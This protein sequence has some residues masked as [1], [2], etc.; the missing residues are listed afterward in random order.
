M[1]V[2]LWLVVSVRS[3]CYLAAIILGIISTTLPGISL[4]ETW[5]HFLCTFKSEHANLQEL[6]HEADPNMYVVSLTSWLFV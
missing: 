4:E 1:N 2:T 3:G 6:L 5:G